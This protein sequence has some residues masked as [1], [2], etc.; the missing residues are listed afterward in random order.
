MANLWAI[1]PAFLGFFGFRQAKSAFF[2]KKCGQYATW[3]GEMSLQAGLIGL[4]PNEMA[5]FGW[6]NW[7]WNRIRPE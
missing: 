2:S 7:V 1:G 3:I 5:G 4:E 6:N